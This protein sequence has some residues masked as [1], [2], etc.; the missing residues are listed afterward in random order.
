MSAEFDLDVSDY[1]SRQQAGAGWNTRYEGLAKGLLKLSDE[2]DGMIQKLE[3]ETK[4]TEARMRKLN[5]AVRAPHPGRQ[6]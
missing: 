5:M 3:G 1:F 4:K 6:G 2:L